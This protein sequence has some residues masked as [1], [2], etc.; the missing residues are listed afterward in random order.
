VH[1]IV[2]VDVSD[3]TSCDKIHCQEVDIKLLF[4]I[5]FFFKDLFIY[6]M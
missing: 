1:G 3:S 4:N 2:K 6:Y 5:M